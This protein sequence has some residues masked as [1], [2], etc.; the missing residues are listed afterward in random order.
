MQRAVRA[1]CKDSPLG[2]SSGSSSK[3]C[4]VCCTAATPPNPSSSLSLSPSLKS[5]LRRNDFPLPVNL[6]A[7]GDAPDGREARTSSCSFGNNS[8]AFFAHAHPLKLGLDIMCGG[9]RAVSAQDWGLWRCGGRWYVQ[10]VDLLSEVSGIREVLRLGMATVPPDLHALFREAQGGGD[11]V[12]EVHGG[13]GGG[14]TLTRRGGAGG[15]G[16]DEAQ[17]RG[18]WC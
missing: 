4:G 7:P 3:I 10:R 5:L 12:D 6:C 17:G 14:W 2:I 15:F 11:G 9:L 1:Q 8:C 16:V 18:G 13:G